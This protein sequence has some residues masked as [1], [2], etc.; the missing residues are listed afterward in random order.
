MKLLRAVVAQS[1]LAGILVTA[2]GGL[3]AMDSGDYS[4]LL[5]GIALLF[6]ALFWHVFS[7]ILDLLTDIRQALVRDEP[8]TIPDN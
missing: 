2:T 1:T 4:G 8:D 3:D 7:N 5:L 6:N